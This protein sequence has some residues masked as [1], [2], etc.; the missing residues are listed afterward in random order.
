MLLKDTEYISVK[1]FDTSHEDAS[2]V[3]RLLISI[4]KSTKVLLNKN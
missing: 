3:L 4:V 2:E 1:E